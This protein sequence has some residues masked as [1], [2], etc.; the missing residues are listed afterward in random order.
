MKHCW[1]LAVSLLMFSFGLASAAEFGPPEPLAAPGKLAIGIGWSHAGE[2]LEPVDRAFLGTQDFWQNTRFSQTAWYLQANLGLVKNW[3]AFA[4]F[5]FASLRGKDTFVYDTGTDN[6]R[7]S[8][9]FFTT[10]GAKGVL[11]SNPAFKMGPFSSFSMGPILKTTFYSEYRD[12]SSGLLGGALVSM[13]YK[14]KDMWDINLAWSMQTKINSLTLFAGPYIFWK[15]L[16]SDLAINVPGVGVF[17]DATNYRSYNNVGGFV[18]LRVPVIKHITL[19]VEGRYV[20]SFGA[21]AALM[22]SF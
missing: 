2:R 15:S 19:D 6:F 22:Y 4:R 16:R 20:D 10:V 13:D 21:S 5:G 7:D 12:S 11:Y 9:Q 8:G 18:G 1:I 3:E 17:A 14:V